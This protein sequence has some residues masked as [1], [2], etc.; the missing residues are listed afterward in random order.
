MQSG[1]ADFKSAIYTEIRFLAC[2]IQRLRNSRR[3]SFFRFPVV[4]AY[5]TS[6]WIERSNISLHFF[7]DLEAKKKTYAA[8]TWA[9]ENAVNITPPFFPSQMKARLRIY[10]L[11]KCCCGELDR[12]YSV[13]LSRVLLRLHKRK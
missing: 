1:I 5:S 7:G 8:S 2:S 6:I 10:S 9:T 12:G 13:W 11:R 3:T 4:T